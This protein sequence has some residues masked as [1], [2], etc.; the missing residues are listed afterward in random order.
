MARRSRPRRRPCSPTSASSP[1]PA[2]TRRIRSLRRSLRKTEPKAL[3]REGIV[4]LAQLA[5]RQLEELRA[6]KDESVRQTELLR[7]LLARLESLERTQ[8][9]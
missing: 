9:S 7:E 4:D 8:Y 1:N 6:L 3:K 2:T 5:E